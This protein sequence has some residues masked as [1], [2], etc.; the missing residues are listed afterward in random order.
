MQNAERCISEE[1]I[2]V[3][4]FVNDH[5]TFTLSSLIKWA[6]DSLLPELQNS[7]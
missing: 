3:A 4:I 2:S 1:V 5:V 7:L 6:S